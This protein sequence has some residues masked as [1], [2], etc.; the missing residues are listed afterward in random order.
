MKRIKLLVQSE[1]VQAKM[2]IAGFFILFALLALLS[3]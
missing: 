1:D 3:N 2:V